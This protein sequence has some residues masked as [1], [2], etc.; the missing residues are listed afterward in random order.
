M[1]RQVFQSCQ[2]NFFI[3]EMLMIFVFFKCVSTSEIHFWLKLE[4]LFESKCFN[5]FISVGRWYSLYREIFKSC[6]F[7]FFIFEI[8]RIFVFIEM[9]FSVW[10]AFL[11]ENE[12]YKKLEF[13]FDSK[14]FNLFLSVRRWY[15]INGQVF[16]SWQ[17]NFFILE[18][19]RIFVF[20]KMRFS[21]SKAFL[22]ENY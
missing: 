22:N 8:F 6:Q 2:V 12:N 17:V 13:L 21:F 10:K 16:K 18:I 1:Y 19:W 11:T 7:N 3:F 14:S 4:F 20:F 15:F 9:C 5:L